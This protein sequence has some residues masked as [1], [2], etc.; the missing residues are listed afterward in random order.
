MK[1]SKVYIS[2]FIGMF[3]RESNVDISLIYMHFL[4]GFC[5]MDGKVHILLTH[6]NICYRA[7]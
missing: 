5:D 4:K 6:I 7:I 3:D 2:F 1:D